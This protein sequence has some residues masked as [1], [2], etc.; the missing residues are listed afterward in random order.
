M[1]RLSAPR[2]L[3]PGRHPYAVA[4]IAVLLL[5]AAVA[6]VRGIVFDTV[7][8]YNV[9]MTLAGEK[10][11]HPYFQLTFYN[12]V[13]G[14]L[15]AALATAM[16][17]VQWYSVVMVLMIFASLTAILGSMLRRGRAVGVPALVV[18]AFFAVLFVAL[19]L[20]PVQ[21]MQFTTTAALLG[22]AACALA[23]SLPPEE[24]AARK[25]APALVASAVF[26][27][28]A[29]VERK[30]VGYC[31]FAFWA[32]SL[33]RFIVYSK[34][35]RPGIPLR[36]FGLRLGSV[37]AIAAIIAVAFYGGDHLIRTLGDNAGYDDYNQWRAEFQD[38]PHPSFADQPALYEENGWSQE[39]Y[40]IAS[41]LIYIDEAIDAD[42]LKAIVT[43]P[44]TREVQP[45]LGEAVDLGVSLVRTNQTAKADFLASL[46][47]LAAATGA[48]AMLTMRRPKRA[49]PIWAGIV[50]LTALACI[51]SL[52]LCLSGRWMLRLLQTICLPY[53]VC[54][55][56]FAFDAYAQLGERSEEARGDVGSGRPRHG[57]L[58]PAA[59]PSAR[60]RTARVL[61]AMAA[62]GCLGI[63]CYLSLGDIGNLQE[64]DAFSKA[65]MAAVEQYAI[66][67]PDEVL[68]HDYSIANYYNSY[69][70]FRTYEKPLTNLIISG[71][72]YT[73]TGAYQHQLGANGL[74]EFLGGGDLLLP[75]VFYVTSLDHPGYLQNVS[76]YLASVYGEV[77][78]RQVDTIADT[79][80]VFK[81]SLTAG[82]SDVLAWQQA[83]PLR[84]DGTGVL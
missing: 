65:Q 12:S 13:F 79:V 26:V 57:R 20:Y 47:L 53:A 33:V 44:L 24:A 67:H 74:D 42:N 68:V 4:G 8:D 14:A 19:F 6:A 66:D 37:F 25:I 51:L 62:F 58:L 54:M 38:H 56:F 17:F 49:I 28:L 15:I 45:S 18:G 41:S 29:A 30:S 75:N 36:R 16:P 83:L 50:L 22:A 69:D 55:M 35:Y 43:S 73:Y 64:R 39:V 60:I 48:C 5:M 71:G 34:A 82:D 32:S 77:S 2:L 10:T 78:V 59:S 3:R 11:G 72:S 23:Y 31:A 1:P 7:D 52:Y 84:A 61:T 70:P 80:G 9:M 46:A 40:R 76:D 27:V 63:S 81:F 21:R